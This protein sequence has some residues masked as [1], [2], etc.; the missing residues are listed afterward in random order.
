MLRTNTDPVSLRCQG[1]LLVEPIGQGQ[2]LPRTV[3]MAS[4]S[5]GQNDRGLTCYLNVAKAVPVRRQ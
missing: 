1:L 4:R 5:F 3:I 2:R